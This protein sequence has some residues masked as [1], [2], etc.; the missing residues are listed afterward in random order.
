MAAA[1]KEQ[2]PPP[3]D[4]GAD[5]VGK[6]EYRPTPGVH[7][8]EAGKVALG[9]WVGRIGN[10]NVRVYYGAPATKIPAAVQAAMAKS[11]VEVGVVTYEELGLVKAPRRRGAIVLPPEA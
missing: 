3:S 4:V 2:A 8:A 1:T 11:G 7:I 5:L 6:V 9:N 10:R